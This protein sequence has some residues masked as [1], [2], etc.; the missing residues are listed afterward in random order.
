MQ[1]LSALILALSLG[2]GAAA[3]ADA[4]S[5]RNVGVVENGLLSMAVADK[6]RRECGDIS[7]RFFKA[8]GFM[9]D[10]IDHARAQG[11]TDAE[12]DAYVSNRAEKNRM[13]AKRDAYLANQGVVQ[14]SPETYCAA[15]RAEI[16][17]SSQIGALLRAR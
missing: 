2:F 10:L 9:R 16:G 6:I 3:D 8:Q 1:K 17:K 13:R 14:S 11:F 15:G 7:A 4:R 12:I 5:L